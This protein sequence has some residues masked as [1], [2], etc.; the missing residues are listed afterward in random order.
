MGAKQKRSNGKT[1]LVEDGL[2]FNEGIEAAATLLKAGKVV[3]FPTETVYGMGGNIHSATAISSIFRIKG[4]PSDNPLIVHIFSKDQLTGLVEFTPDAAL[5]LMNHFWPGP[6]TLV[7]NKRSSVSD[8]VTA[9]LQTVSVR[10]PSNSI[11][12]R[13]L[14]SAGV[15]VAAPSANLSGRPSITTFEE[16]RLEL[17]GKVDAIIDGGK[18]LFGVESTVL[19][20]SRDPPLLLRPGAVTVEELRKYVRN[21]QVHPAAHGYASAESV[22]PS[23]GMRYRHYAP[24]NARVILFEGEGAIEALSSA[25]E[26]CRRKGVS[27]ASVVTSEADLAG[28]D[29][30][31]SGSAERPETIARELFLLLRKLDRA[32][33]EYILIEG[34]REEGMGL[35]VMNRIRRAATAVNPDVRSLLNHKNN[36]K[37]PP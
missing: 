17:E 8:M 7:M 27:C 32:G 21:L 11:A 5:P 4:R 24:V 33:Y 22:V 3:V 23:P 1:L 30:F 16:A 31:I 19:D 29:V 18:T 13:L 36:R 26:L 37:L 10:M 12:L 6:L 34:I 28:T 9:G 14:R 2:F 20:V 25:A 35:A 15:P